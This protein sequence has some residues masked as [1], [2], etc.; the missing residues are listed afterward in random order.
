MKTHEI[1]ALL[2]KEGEGDA[3]PI[4]L[5]EDRVALLTQEIDLSRETSK[6]FVVVGPDKLNKDPSEELTVK[7]VNV[8]FA[9]KNLENVAQVETVPP[10]INSPTSLTQTLRIT[11]KSSDTAE[12]IN[13][14]LD[15]LDELYDAKLK[16]IFD[17]APKPK[18]H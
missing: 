6:R 3:T 11:F 13:G 15:A 16:A 14:T 17:A 5:T 4:T 12:Q 1:S 18:R 8:R 2:R 7:C 10:V 9:I